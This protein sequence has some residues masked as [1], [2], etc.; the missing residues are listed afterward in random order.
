MAIEKT[1]FLKDLN[2]T[3]SFGKKLSALLKPGDLI[4][5]SGDLGS[6]KTTCV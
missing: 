6:G 3:N 5:L 1:I 4:Y 2:E